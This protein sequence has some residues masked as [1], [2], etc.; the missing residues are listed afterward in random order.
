M[1]T[2]LRIDRDR[3]LARLER[4]ARIGALPSGGVCRLALSDGDKAARD[5]VV[6]WMRELGLAVTVDR[7]GNIVG[8]RPGLRAGR[9]GLTASTV[10]RLAPAAG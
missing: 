10:A 5:L 9:R 6:A 2:N 1:T 7:I 8:V 4:L 3:L